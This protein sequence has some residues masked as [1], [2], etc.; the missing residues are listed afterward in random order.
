MATAS[1]RTRANA[2]FLTILV[3]HQGD[4]RAETVEGGL[5]YSSCF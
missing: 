2:E 4:N 3:G 5:T 1:Q